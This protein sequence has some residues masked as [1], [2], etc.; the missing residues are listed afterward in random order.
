[1][2]SSSEA[3]ATVSQYLDDERFHQTFRLPSGASRATEFKVTYADF[4][5]R[6]NEHVLLFCGPLL[7]SRY[8][9]TTKD[10]LAQEN[11]IR[12]IC[13]DRP[14]F[15]GTTSDVPLSDRVRVWLDIVETLLKH[16]A[17]RY[18][19]VVG[20]SGGSIYAM[21]VVFHLRHLLHPVRPYVALLTPWVHPSHSGVSALKIAGLLP[22]GLVGSYD[23]LLQ[24]VGNMGSAFQFSNILSGLVPS[25]SQVTAPLD[26]GVDPDAV[27]LEESLSSELFRRITNEDVSGIS[28][29]S[30]LLLK[31]D[32]YP[33]CWGTWKDYD[34]LVPLLAEA[35]RKRRTVD[36][37]IVPPLKVHVFFAE[38]DGMIGTKSAPAWL[39]HCWRP[40]QRGDL[41][42]YYSE[43]IPKTSHNNILDLRYGVM[44][45]IFQ[46]MTNW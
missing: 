15:G 23:R 44:N 46:E 43:T 9:L 7:G 39:N 4:G 6:N 13:P 38:S 31:R 2:A 17:I 42:D 18:V 37:D 41:I 8:L 33:G 11:G 14:G 28:Q 20:Y 27:A 10:K 40:E 12:V 35:E 24:V 30:L 34:T 1:M 3:N 25:L 16:L 32:A 19:S 21:N 29:D 5:H 36:S 26:Q 45:Q 22:N